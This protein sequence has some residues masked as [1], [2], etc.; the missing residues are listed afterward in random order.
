MKTIKNVDELAVAAIRA[1]C[2]DG[3][4]KAKS[5]HPGASLG[6]AP[7]MYELYKDFFVS[8]PFQPEWINRDRLVL[9]CGHA[10]ML[11]YTILH[12]CSYD[13][14][15]EDLQ[16]FRQL[17]SRTPGHPEV[18]FTPGIDAGSGPLG[19]GIAEAVGMA[20]AETMLAAQYGSKLYNHYTYC[21]AGDGCLEEGISQEAIS[22]AGLHRLNKLILIYD[23]NDITLDGSLGLSSIENVE[24][25]FLANN[26]N[27]IR[28]RNGNNLNAIK[29]ALRRAKKSTDKPTLII[30][31]TIIGYGSKNQ[32]TNKVHGNP[33]GL[34]D[35]T[36]AKLSYGY[37]YPPFEIPQEVYDQLKNTFLKR[38]EEAYQ[39][40]QNIIEK[41]QQD[42]PFLYTKLMNLASNDITEYLNKKHLTMDELS[43]EST[44][45]TSLRV[46]NYYHEL[47]PNFV[48][49]SADVASSVM[50]KLANG[51][52][53]SYKNRAGTNINWGV[54]EFFMAAAT[55][56]ILLHGGLRTYT[57][58]FLVFSDYMKSAIR[59][60]ALQKLPNIYLFSHDSLA[61]GEDGPTHQPIEHL[62]GL[63]A[64]P[65]LYVFRP[66]D[67]KETYAAYRI[68]LENTKTPS[69]IVLSRQN[70]SLLKKSSNYES[71]KKGAYIVSKERGV[72]PQFTIIATGS[73]V[74]LAL[75]VKTYLY[76]LGVDIRVV[77]MPCVELFDE[78]DTAYQ[79]SVLGNSYQHRVTLEMASTFGW[80][81]YA[82]Y[83]IGIDTFGASGK[84][85]DVIK[86][87]GFTRENIAKFI[88]KRV[89]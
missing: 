80:N 38:G 61:V 18:E 50:T 42:D 29:K 13:I 81:K 73:E 52:S 66:C 86:H 88:L 7:L 6:L 4:N 22:F 34:E 70:L 26:W 27:V 54:K 35:G 33:L 1:T 74:S 77:S 71:V 20:L 12:L 68:A 11:L 17:G 39:R 43:S 63:R 84:A 36:Y 16:N 67:A 53:Y 78:Q 2:I 83:S 49:G 89:K 60:S 40:Y 47:L 45:N 37:N 3:I 72:R 65:N 23:S 69:A 64:T 5:G 44:R 62:A 46:L 75:E 85:D 24:T 19:Q 79:L 14:S 28:V 51:S 57:G 31:K 10:S 82:K 8:N 48:G 9:S 56:G 32:G 55:N 58:C 87:F 15:L 25:R 41:V 21:I 59:M 30:L 76:S